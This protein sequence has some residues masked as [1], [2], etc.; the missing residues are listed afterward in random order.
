MLED[1]LQPLLGLLLGLAGA[2]VI[3][4]YVRVNARA[5]GLGS[6]AHWFRGILLAVTGMGLHWTG[7]GVLCL[8]GPWIRLGPFA[9]IGAVMCLGGLCLYAWSARRVG[10]WKAPAKYTLEL[11]VEGIY[12]HVRHPQALALCL[13]AIG[14][15]LVS[16]SV[17]FLLSLPLWLAFWFTYTC[18]EER[19][20]L[21][22]AF[23]DE[24]LRYRETTPRLF[25]RLG[26]RGRGPGRRG[27]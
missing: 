1:W 5:R 14:L 15:G 23:G 27:D 21:I 11:R 4:G 12:R 16:G 3:G 19:W 26:R 18:L 6:Q 20:E 9:W 7:W 10:R 17:P 24:Y 8:S 25:P 13:A 22:P 2:L